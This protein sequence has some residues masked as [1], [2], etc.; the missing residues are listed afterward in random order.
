[1]TSCGPS[2]RAF[3]VTTPARVCPISAPM[4]RPDVA[5]GLPRSSESRI[6]LTSA[7]SASYISLRRGIPDGKRGGGLTRGIL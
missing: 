1:M 3:E 5:P 2:T 6:F 4:T 7:L